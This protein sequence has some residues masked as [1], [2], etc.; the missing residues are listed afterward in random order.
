MNDLV[1]KEQLA[2]LPDRDITDGI[3]INQEIWHTMHHSKR[4]KN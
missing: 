1:G 2:F 4:K 3:M